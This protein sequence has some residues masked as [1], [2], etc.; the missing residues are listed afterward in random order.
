M[1]VHVTAAEKIGPPPIPLPHWEVFS[2]KVME[3]KIPSRID[4]REMP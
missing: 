2:E 1:K 4:M 3:E